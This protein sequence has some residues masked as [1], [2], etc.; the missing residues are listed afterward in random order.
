MFSKC[1]KQ[2]VK[3]CSSFKILVKSLVDLFR[4]T[5]RTYPF[6]L[7]NVVSTLKLLL[8]HNQFYKLVYIINVLLVLVWVINH[9]QALSL[10]LTCYISV[11]SRALMICLICTLMLLGLTALELGCTYQA[12]LP[13][14]MI[15][16]LHK[17]YLLRCLWYVYL[18]TSDQRNSRGYILP[19]IKTNSCVVRSRSQHT[20]PVNILTGRKKMWLSHLRSSVLPLQSKTFFLMWTRPPTSVLHIPNLSKIASS[21][22]E[23]HDFKNWLSF[24]IF[25]LL[26]FF[27][28]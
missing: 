27:F 18:D 28:F 12:I 16:L 13:E 14:P 17:A 9:S 4:D 3:R 11:V 22:S 20:I 21:V 23:I 15:Q 8:S 6:M 26:I 19:C 2:S 5:L 10:Q 24:L 7:T 25:F 1:C